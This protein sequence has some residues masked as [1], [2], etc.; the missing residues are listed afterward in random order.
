MR[1]FAAQFLHCPAHKQADSDFSPGEW[2]GDG[3]GR[4]R[5]VRFACFRDVGSTSGS[6]R[7]AVSTTSPAESSGALGA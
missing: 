4:G 6:E 3:N 1:K 5:Q 2:H 7:L